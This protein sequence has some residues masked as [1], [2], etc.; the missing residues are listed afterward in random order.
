MVFYATGESVTVDLTTGV[1]TPADS[2]VVGVAQVETA[3]A[4]GTITGSGNATVVFTSAAVTGS[5]VTVPVAVTNGDTAAQWAEKVRTALAAN[6]DISDKFTISGST[7]SIVATRKSTTIATGFPVAYAANDSTLNISLANGTCTGIT[8]ASTSA[9][10]TAGVATE[11]A[12]VLDGD[13][14][15][16][17]GATLD[18]ITTVD[19]ALFQVATG[20]VL[21]TGLTSANQVVMATDSM[22]LFAGSSGLGT[23][24]AEDITIEATSGPSFVKLTVIGE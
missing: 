20:P 7:T 18:T 4:A 19:G 12:Y 13:G 6:T 21:M 1:A 23:N 11:G 2:H 17:E 14:K 3:T 8:T 5:P 24:F 22:S 9:N 15:D 16:F 10:T